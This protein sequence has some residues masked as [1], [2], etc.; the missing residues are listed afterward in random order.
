[1]PK[2][3]LNDLNN[4]LFEQLERLNDID[5]ENDDVEA[6][7]KEIKRADAIGKVSKQIIKNATLALRGK[8]YL[9]TYGVER[10][11]V[12][13]VLQLQEKEK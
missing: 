8:Q 9:D 12:P 13:E 3:T 4:I 11:E 5:M 7:D 6:L 1:M 10:A 2:N